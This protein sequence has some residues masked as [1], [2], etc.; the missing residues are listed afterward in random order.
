MLNP[1]NRHLVLEEVEIEEE[2]EEGSLVLV[3][4]DYKLKKQSVHGVYKVVGRAQD[5]EKINEKIVGKNVVV[6]EGMV[7]K[8]SLGKEKYYLVLEN[9]VYGSY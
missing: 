6:E 1:L 4:E 9:Y 3:P 7:Q 5:C 2:K 8:V